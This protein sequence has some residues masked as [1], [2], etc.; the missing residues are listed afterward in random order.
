LRHLE[1]TSKESLQVQT[2]VG[3]VLKNHSWTAD[4]RLS[5]RLRDA[6]TNGNS[7]H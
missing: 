6:L 3:N 2:V 5:S 7:K 4:K 1:A